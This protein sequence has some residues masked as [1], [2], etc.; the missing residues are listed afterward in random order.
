MVCG[1][2]GSMHLVCRVD[3]VPSCS[4]SLR[5]LSSRSTV[6]SPLCGT[7]LRATRSFATGRSR[8]RFRWLTPVL[9]L[10]ALGAAAYTVWPY[11]DEKKLPMSAMHF[12]PL[13][14]KRIEPLNA[15]SALF[16]FDLPAKMKPFSAE[17]NANAIESVYVVQ[18]DIQIQRPY[19]P[20]DA[21]A[22]GEAG[23]SEFQLLVKR[24][25][26]GEMSKWLHRRQPGDEVKFRGPV[27]TWTW[28]PEMTSITFIAGGTGI[29]PF[30]QLVQM[31]SAKQIKHP[32]LH[33][34]YASTSAETVLFEKELHEH[35]KRYPGKVSTHLTIDANPTGAKTAAAT[36]RLASAN[37]HKWLP[38]PDE[39]AR[40]IVSG[41]E[42]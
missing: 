16:T 17:V 15:N 37:L 40:L 28:R 2:K 34:V 30:F 4:M 35:V 12:V 13:P 31:L 1:W 33:L 26:D 25:D 24:Y 38:E 21:S 19:T 32:D 29:T 23:D 20:L 18:P 22:F 42:G 9:G 10:S 3:R 14:I 8:R 11:L 5:C 6:Y 36:G 41:P 39:G 27:P 7:S